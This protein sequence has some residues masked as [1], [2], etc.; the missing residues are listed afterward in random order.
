M[1]PLIVSAAIEWQCGI[2]TIPHLTPARHHGDGPRV[3]AARA[4]AEGIRNVLAVTGDPPRSATTPARAAST[5]STRRLTRLISQLNR[6]GTTTARRSTPHVV[7]HRRRRQPERRRPEL[8]LDRFRR[9]VDEGA[10]FARRRSSSTSTIST[11]SWPARR[12]VAGAGARGRVPTDELPARAPVCT[13]R[14][15]DR[16]PRAVAGALREGV[17]EAEIVSPTRA[18]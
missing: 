11:G 3:G 6:G 12:A 2:E 8:E 7:L 13:T 14:P 1:H 18:S 4:H 15:R 16:R 10:S 9:K 5:R 17:T